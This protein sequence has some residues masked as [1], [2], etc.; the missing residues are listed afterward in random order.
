MIIKTRRLEKKNLI[1]QPETHD[2]PTSKNP[3]KKWFDVSCESQEDKIVYLLT[4]TALTYVSDWPV[5]ELMDK[6]NLAS[7]MEFMCIAN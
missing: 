7:I 1:F 4:N 3:I 5:A 6:Y 2:T